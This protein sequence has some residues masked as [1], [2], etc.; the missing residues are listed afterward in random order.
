M[1]VHK[2]QYIA[3]TNPA[4]IQQYTKD[5]EEIIDAAIEGN[6]KLSRRKMENHLRKVRH[7]LTDFIKKFP[8]L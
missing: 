7:I 2:Y 3:T 4:F 1:R 8:M 6:Q 5:H